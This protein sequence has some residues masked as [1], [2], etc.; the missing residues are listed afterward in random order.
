[1]IKY[2]KYDLSEVVIVDI[3]NDKAIIKQYLKDGSIYK[4]EVDVL[5]AMRLVEIDDFI[6]SKLGE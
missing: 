6:L 2:Y 5:T 3:D 4:K 1:M